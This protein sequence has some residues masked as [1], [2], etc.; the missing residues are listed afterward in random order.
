MAM[1]GLRT[2]VFLLALAAS[3]AE[4]QFY[5]PAVYNN[6]ANIFLN[7]EINRI[8]IN[9][10]ISQPSTRPAPSAR[11]RLQPIEDRVMIAALEALRPG[12]QRR[13][14]AD[15]ERE[16]KAWYV[17]TA[18]NLGHDM[19]SLVSE[20]RRK[21]ARQGEARADGWYIA[22]ARSAGKRYGR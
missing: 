22:T 5:D 17:A 1:N 14:A 13:W 11:R 7:G 16:A 8:T 18:R 20:Y 15:G 3:A 10:G 2:A 21:V 9:S 6:Q 12:L 19:G 4:A